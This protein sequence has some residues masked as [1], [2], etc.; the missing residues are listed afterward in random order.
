M[1]TVRWSRSSASNREES[2]PLCSLK[3]S[4]S[5][6][7]ELEIPCRCKTLPQSHGWSSTT[8]PWN[9]CARRALEHKRSPLLFSCCNVL[10][11]CL[12]PGYIAG[13]CPR[14]HQPLDLR[15]G[16]FE[17]GFSEAG[18]WQRHLEVA[19][20]C[21]ELADMYYRCHYG[22]TSAPSSSKIVRANFLVV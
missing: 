13:R 8:V 18:R 19:R 9:N 20:S 17:R 2:L 6:P 15:S 16:A 3:S 10:K 7:T 1:T 12:L 21:D 22:S 4:D 5:S 11:V 14:M